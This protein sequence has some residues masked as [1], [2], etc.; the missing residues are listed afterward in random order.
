MYC[1]NSSVKKASLQVFNNVNNNNRTNSVN[2]R[3]DTVTNLAKTS[4]LFYIKYNHYRTIVNNNFKFYI[5]SFKIAVYKKLQN[6][7]VVCT[8]C[9]GNYSWFIDR[10]PVSPIIAFP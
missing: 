5:S 9:K 4:A 6:R 10:F 8:G 2:R 3:I 7:R 1:L